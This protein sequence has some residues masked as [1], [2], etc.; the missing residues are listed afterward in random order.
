M[1]EHES[2]WC[3][4]IDDTGTHAITDQRVHPWLACPAHRLSCTCTPRCN[5]THAMPCNTRDSEQPHPTLVQSEH[6]IADDN[7]AGTTVPRV[8]PVA[9]SASTA[10]GT[11]CARHAL[12]AAFVHATTAATSAITTGEGTASSWGT[13]SATAKVA[14]HTEL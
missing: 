13:S 2:A 5:S 6:L 8:G 7:D 3:V 14:I 1:H 4:L 10:A 12:A 11:V 9:R